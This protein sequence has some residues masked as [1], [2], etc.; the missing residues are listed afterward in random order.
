[1]TDKFL[2]NMQFATI[3]TLVLGITVVLIIM[4]AVIS[5]FTDVIPGKEYT[6]TNWKFTEMEYCSQYGMEA[7]EYI[8]TECSFLSCQDVEKTKCSNE[9]NE[10]KINYEWERFCKY[11]LKA[12]YNLC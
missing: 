11:K 9:I 7:I 4:I 5:S 2:K 10:K 8:S 1:M 12:D 6:E 3:S